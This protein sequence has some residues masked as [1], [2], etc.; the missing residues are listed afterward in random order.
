MF[1]NRKPWMNKEIHS[2][3]KV[4]QTTFKSGDT[5][6]YRKSRYDLRRAIREAKRQYR[7]KLDQAHQN[8]SRRRW[9]GL[10]DITGY[11]SK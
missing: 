6:R 11:K 1:P 2:L 3:L 8:D 7:D 4:R 5:K 10:S 9:Q